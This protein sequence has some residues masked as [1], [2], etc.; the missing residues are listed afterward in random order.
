MRTTQNPETSVTNGASAG[1]ASGNFDIMRASALQ[2]AR[3]C[4]W[5]GWTW[6]SFQHA[7]V[8]AN[9]KISDLEKRCEELLTALKDLAKEIP[10]SRFNIRK[11][12]SLLNAHACATKAI[13]NA[14][15]GSK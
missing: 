12:F 3:V 2:N 4:K 11:D 10:L 5:E 7:I 1:D 9:Y 6:K 8:K 13:Y 14:E 15:R